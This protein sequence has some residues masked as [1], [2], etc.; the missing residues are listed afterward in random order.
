MHPLEARG[1]VCAGM[2]AVNYVIART[3]TG[4]LTCARH[5]RDPGGIAW[6]LSRSPARERFGLCRSPKEPGYVLSRLPG[7]RGLGGPVERRAVEALAVGA[8]RF[9]PAECDEY[10][11]GLAE[12]CAHYG[13]SLRCAQRRRAVAPRM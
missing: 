8:V 13:T 6:R 10:E 7:T 9:A 1:N 3:S 11:A 5:V 12:E 2:K 4:R